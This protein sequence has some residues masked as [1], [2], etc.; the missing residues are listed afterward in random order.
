MLALRQEQM[1]AFSQYMRNGFIKRMVRHLRQQFPQKTQSF[2]HNN[3]STIVEQGISKA[4]QYKIY[5]ECDVERYLDLM[6]LLT[7]DFDTHYQTPWAN[8]ILRKD[9]EASVKLDVLHTKAEI[10]LRGRDYA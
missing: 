7:I 3:L 6:F 9:W 2:D 8:P 1:V 10:F 4:E 5:R